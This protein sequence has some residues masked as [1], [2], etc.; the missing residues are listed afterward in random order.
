MYSSRQNCSA[1]AWRPARPSSYSA[2]MSPPA[3]NARSPGATTITRLTASSLAHSASCAARAR[4]MAWVMALSALG[5]LSVTM[6]AAPR[7]A[8]R[9]SASVMRQNGPVWRKSTRAVCNPDGTPAKCS[10]PPG[11]Q[12]RGPGDE[13]QDQHDLAKAGVVEPAIELQTE[14]GAEEQHGQAEQ[15]QPH[16]SGLKRSAGA[17]PQAGHGEDGHAHRL[18][19]GALLVLAPAAQAAQ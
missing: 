4:T 16:R 10:G 5:R 9:I 18:E 8:N 1:S 19:H 13:Q 3:E 17:E 6:P 15:E 2:R 12:K 7:R 11:Q 14:P